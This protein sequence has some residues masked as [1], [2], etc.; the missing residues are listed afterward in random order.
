MEK[1]LRRINLG[2]LQD[3]RSSS[4]PERKVAWGTESRVDR[5]PNLSKSMIDFTTQLLCL[6]LLVGVAIVNT[7]KNATKLEELNEAQNHWYAYSQQAGFAIAIIGIPRVYYGRKK[8][9]SRTIW[10][11]IIDLFRQ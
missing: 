9:I 11:R 2:T 6:L 4:P 1:T 10:R 3:R 8:Y 5:F 7:V